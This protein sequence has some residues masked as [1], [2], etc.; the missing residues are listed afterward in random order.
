MMNRMA[1]KK[2]GIAG[3]KCSEICLLEKKLPDRIAIIQLIPVII[4]MIEKFFARV[5]S[6]GERSAIE[7]RQILRFP[8]KKPVIKRVKIRRVKL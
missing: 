1:V 5:F 3:L 4:I 6:S 7:A 2:N 8:E